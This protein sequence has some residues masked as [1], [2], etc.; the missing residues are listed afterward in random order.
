V[1]GMELPINALNFV[2]RPVISV[3]S[4]LIEQNNSQFLR[5]NVLSSLEAKLSWGICLLFNPSGFEIDNNFE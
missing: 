4:L 3:T 2:P 5:G 1:H